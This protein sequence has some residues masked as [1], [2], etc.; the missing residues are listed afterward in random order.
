MVPVASDLRAVGAHVGPW[1]GR[2]G[3]TR[4]DERGA[5]PRSQHRKGLQGHVPSY[6]V[7]DGIAGGHLAREIFRSVI[8]HLIGTQPTYVGVV[9]GAGS[10]RD[11]RSDVLRELDRKTSDSPGTALDQDCLA[12]REL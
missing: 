1:R 5:T 10:G 6:G 3:R 8:D 2:C 4:G 12:A 7:E 9:R 11:A